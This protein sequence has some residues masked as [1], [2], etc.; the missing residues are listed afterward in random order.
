MA[1]EPHDEAGEDHAEAELL[2]PRVGTEEAQLHQT[3]DAAVGVGVR[4]ADVFDEEAQRSVPD[5]DD[6]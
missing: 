5:A 3:E 6:L 2:A 1:E 4:L